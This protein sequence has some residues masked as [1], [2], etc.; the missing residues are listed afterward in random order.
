MTEGLHQAVSVQEAC[1][2]AGGVGRAESRLT[3]KA[4]RQRIAAAIFTFEGWTALTQA[5]RVAMRTLARIDPKIE[6]PG[7]CTG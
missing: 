6:D 5:Q 2:A 3:E 4:S 1:E 7:W